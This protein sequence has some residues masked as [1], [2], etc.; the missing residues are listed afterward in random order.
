[1]SNAVETLEL[2]LRK[3]EENGQSIALIYPDEGGD[4]IRYIFSTGIGKNS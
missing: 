4:F 1:M 2:L 3:T